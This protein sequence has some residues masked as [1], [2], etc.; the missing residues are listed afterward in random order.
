M[1]GS[2]IIYSQQEVDF[3]L[4]KL[5]LGSLVR[6]D[7]LVSIHNLFTVNIFEFFFCDQTFTGQMRKK[8][9][10]LVSFF[11]LELDILT[12]PSSIAWHAVRS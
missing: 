6:M 2:I 8:P 11:R 9:E 1:L 10:S 3:Y 12:S 5:N 4:D 7:K